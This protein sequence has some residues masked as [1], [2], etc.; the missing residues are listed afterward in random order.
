M[1]DLWWT[2]DTCGHELY[3]SRELY[4]HRRTT[5]HH[6]AQITT[7]ECGPGPGSTPEGRQRAR[8]VYAA[9]LAARR[10]DTQP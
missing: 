3:T 4:D 8:E 7:H 10:Q 2:C 6:R 9:T 1:T 5:G